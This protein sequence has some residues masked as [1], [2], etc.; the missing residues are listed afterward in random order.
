[1]DLHAITRFSLDET[2]EKL[3][4]HASGLSEKEAL[5]RIKQNGLNTLVEKDKYALLKRLYTSF[6][7]PLTLMLLAAS[8]IS[9]ALGDRTDFI[10]ITSIVILSGVIT[11]YQHQKSEN[12][13]EKL[14]KKTHLTATVIR[15]GDEKEIPFAHITIGDIVV[16]QTGDLIPADLR[17]VDSKD[18]TIDESTLTGESFP[19]DKN[20]TAITKEKVSLSQMQNMCFA[21]THVVTGEGKGIVIAIGKQTQLGH[22]SHEIIHA[23]PQT[24]F[25]RDIGNFSSLVVRL[26]ILLTIF[27]F[28]VNAL[29]HHGI[30][31]SLLFSVALAVGLT[32]ELMPV[33][34]TVALSKGALQMEKKEVIVKFLPAIQNLGSMNI[35]CT[36]KT[37][38]LTE[39]DVA[40]SGYEDS[41]GKENNTILEA[42]IIHSSFDLA[43]T[44]PLN[45]A[46]LKYPHKVN[47]SAYKKIEDIQFDFDRKRS[48]VI[49]EKDKKI[50]FI[51]RGAALSIIE[52]CTHVYPNMRCGEK[53]KKALI[54]E[55]EKLSQ[56]GIRV[57]AIA[58]KTIA[59]KDKYT[60]KDEEGLTFLGYLLY[61]DPIKET[62]RHTVKDLQTLGIEIKILTGDNEFITQKV[63]VD[64]GIPVKGIL[65][66]SDIDKITFVELTQR[67][68][69][70]TIFARLS[71]DQKESIIKAFKHNGNTTGFMGDGIND[72]PPLKQ[73]DIGI[74]VNTGADIAKEVADIVLVRK[75]LHVLKEGIIEGRKTHQNIFKYIIMSVSSNFGNMITVA[76][77]SIFLPFLPMLP[78]QIILLDFIYDLSQIAIPE[79]T[80]DDDVVRKPSKW[81]MKYVKKFMIIFGPISS[82]FD[83]V[84]IGG[85]LFVFHASQVFFRTGWFVE[86]L[87]SQSLIIFAI[88]TRK[89]PFWKSKPG[90]SLLISVLVGTVIGIILPFSPF[91]SYFSFQP[92]PILYFIFLGV[93]VFAYFSLVELI[94]TEI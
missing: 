3:H 35:L 78:V 68:D 53:E 83:F 46:T 17:L 49:V 26:I 85:L 55:Y 56:A 4:S 86:S 93:I 77:A 21:G 75:S 5:S 27:I 60:P 63:C 94:K 71:P 72:A 61:K 88:R 7:S 92:L 73:A 19:V 51:C 31:N 58:Q 41:H 15:D 90:I 52:K 40:L 76:A 12:A 13:I 66:G 79:D 84:T 65:T 91:A 11:F 6:F 1:M 18:V 14:K 25:D 81:S 37:G 9:A 2:F 44:N 74:S 50:L 67:V 10:I 42:A 57:L 89:V 45:K 32:P 29:L 33:I 30:F 20:A 24:A 28:F 47:L 38:T 36:D 39:G 70:T 69:A 59:K 82:L 48:S 64:S 8:F 62:V 87:V 22:L 16:V 23:K 80:V 34:I 43:V 54:H